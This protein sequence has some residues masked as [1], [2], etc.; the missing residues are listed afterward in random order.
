MVYSKKI[1][2]RLSIGLCHFVSTILGKQSLT[3][4]V[5]NQQVHIEE[6]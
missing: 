3:N 1:S 2:I 6:S 5:I 4:A